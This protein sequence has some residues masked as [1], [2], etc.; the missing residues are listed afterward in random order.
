MPFK[1]RNTRLTATRWS[2]CGSD[3]CHASKM[4]SGLTPG[5]V[6][7]ESNNKAQ[8]MSQYKVLLTDSD[9][10]KPVTANEGSMTSRRRLEG[11][12]VYCHRFTPPNRTLA[13]V[14]N[15]VCIAA[16]ADAVTP[17]LEDASVEDANAMI[18]TLPNS[19]KIRPTS[20]SWCQT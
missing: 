19:S 11:Q 17:M 7:V 13:M 4:T 12:T 2:L 10:F 20:I 14:I 16:V 9:W 1:Q 3:V 18:I 6:V 5:L 8:I 15:G